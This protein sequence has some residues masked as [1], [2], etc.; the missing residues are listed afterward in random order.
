MVVVEATHCSTTSPLRYPTTP[1]LHFS[2]SP[3]LLS[4]RAL[5]TPMVVQAKP[6]TTVR[7]VRV[8]ICVICE[9]CG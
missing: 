6:R 9:I 1:L 7:D 3:F 2:N 5:A 4:P 8:R